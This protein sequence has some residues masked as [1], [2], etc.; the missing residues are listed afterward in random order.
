LQ[1]SEEQFKDA[2]QHSAVGTALVDLEG[3]YIE[4]NERLCEILG[5][6][7]AEMKSMKFQDITYYKDLKQDLI[8]KENLDSG[9]MAH[10]NTDKRFVH[11]NKSIVWTHIS[12]SIVI[13]NKSEQAHYIVQIIDI[14]ERKKIERENKLLTKENNRNKMIQLN[15]VKNMYRL[16]ADN[17]VDLVCLHNLDT[18]FQ[19][20]SPSIKKLLGYNPEALIGKL[21]Q[22]FVHPDDVKKLQNTIHGFISEMEDVSV[23]LRFRDVKGNYFWFETK[24]ILVKEKGIPISF[25]SSTR[26]ITQQKEAEEIVE[27]TLIQER[28]LNELRS[29]LVSTISHEFRTPMTTIRASAELIAMYLKEYRFENSI[30]VDKRV[31]M[32]TEEIDRIVE[33]MNAVLTISKNDSGKTNFNPV[34]FD[35]KQVCID[36]IETSYSSQNDKRKVQTSFKG[37]TFHIFADKKLMEY[38][39]FNVLNNA[40][41]YSEGFGDIILN[42]FTADGATVIEIIDFGIGVPEK[43]QSKLFNTFF[44]AS[45]TEGFQG[46]GLGLYIVKTFTEKNSGTVQ[47]ETQIGKGTK[48]TLKFPMQN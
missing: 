4:I 9:K 35:L 16:L 15:E 31:N 7:N 8:N 6:S 44:R 10:F 19:Y 14:T 11:K 2:F 42:L 36:V 21:P 43:D 5:Y 24:A 41:K 40:F 48:V 46:T 47:L 29:N 38:S 30:H 26:D 1:Q 39:L 12:V 17:T 25:Q 13:K 37:D 32:I 45:N 18:S 23:R 28:E 34:R 22:E 20:V 33:L 3:N 27:N